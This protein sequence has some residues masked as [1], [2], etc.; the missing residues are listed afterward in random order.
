MI[1]KQLYL[2]IKLTV[3]IIG[4]NLKTYLRKKNKD[5]FI[6]AEFGTEGGALTYFYYLLDYFE[7]KNIHYYL[8]LSPA[9]IDADTLLKDRRFCKGIIP[10]YEIWRPYLKKS[11]SFALNLSYVLHQCNEL[12]FFSRLNLKFRPDLFYFSVCNPEHYLIEFCLRARVFYICHTLTND[13]ID[14]L[15]KRILNYFLSCNKRIIVVSKAAK[16]LLLQNWKITQQ[17]SCFIYVVYNFYECDGSVPEIKM[18][19]EKFNILTIGSLEWYKNPFLWI[20]TAIELT[21]K[22]GENKV[23]FIWVGT[24]TLKNDCESMIKSFDNIHFR[25]YQNKV[26]KFYTNADVYIQ[27]SFSESFGIAVVGAMAHG[28]PCIVSNSGG[29]S[30]VVKNGKTGFVLE[31]KKPEAYVELLL[32]IYDNPYESIKLGMKGYDRFKEL[33]TKDQWY[34]SMENVLKN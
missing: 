8:V 5:V 6:V 9:Q 2:L 12:L 18:R 17:K 26:E 21:R 28:L 3:K 7:F 24:G 15:N 19:G 30:E 11:N 22:L 4:L 20:E 29:L 34:Q 13:P 1:L 31:Q 23:E 25:G 27:P 16:V 14:I 32:F 33:F 10:G